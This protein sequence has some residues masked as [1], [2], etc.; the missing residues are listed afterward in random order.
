MMMDR[1]RQTDIQTDGWT[2]R[3]GT[4]VYNAGGVR[5]VHTPKSARQMDCYCAAYK[6]VAWMSTKTTAGI[7]LI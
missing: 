2:D 4:I 1:Q 7:E 5:D 3:H 6:D